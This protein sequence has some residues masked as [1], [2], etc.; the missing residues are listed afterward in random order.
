[1]EKSKESMAGRPML[2]AVRAANTWSQ[3]LLSADCEMRGATLL[4]A[5]RVLDR[6][7]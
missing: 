3:C 2:G 4:S 6:V 5:F 1:M 7:S